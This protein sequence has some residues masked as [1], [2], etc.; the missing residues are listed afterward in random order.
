MPAGGR[1]LAL[2]FSLLLLTVA[3]AGGSFQPFHRG[4]ASRS[5]VNG[6]AGLGLAIVRQLTE[7]RG[8]RTQL[9][10]RAGGGLEAWL[11]IGLTP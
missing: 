7:A 11:T 2:V 5:P 1:L 8:W 6:G 9:Q 10:P 3:I 4:D